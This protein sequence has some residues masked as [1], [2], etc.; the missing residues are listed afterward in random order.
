M[1]R[2][3][4]PIFFMLISSGIYILYVDPTYAEIKVLRAKIDAVEAS[5]IDADTAKQKID[6]LAK[7]ESSFPADYVIKLR[8][9]LPDSIDDT[10]LIIDVNAMALRDGLHIKN[11]KISTENTSVKKGAPA[12]IAHN[13]DFTVTAPYSA[14]RSF[15]HDMEGNLSL[16]DMGAISFSS[17]TGDAEALKYR[18]PEQIPHEYHVSFTTYSLP[19]H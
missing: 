18:N 7:V 1:K 16:R 5:K 19:S 17:Q 6:K 12:Y 11:P 8:T 3:I 10:R 15:L 2:F 4:V 14:F 9:L 13:I